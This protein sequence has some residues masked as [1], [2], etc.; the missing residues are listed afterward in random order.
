[1]NTAKMSVIALSIAALAGCAAP[2]ERIIAQ[3]QQ[4][5]KQTQQRLERNQ[6]LMAQRS[7][8]EIGWWQ[9]LHSDELNPA[10]G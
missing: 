10:G 6:V 3:A 2:G 4:A 5:E 9:Q 7:A 8:D 1:M